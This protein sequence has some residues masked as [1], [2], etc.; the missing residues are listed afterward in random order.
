MNEAEWTER[1]E[2]L[3]RDHR[4]LKSFAL[5]VFFLALALAGIYAIRPARKK[6]TARELDI[7]DSAGTVR[8]RLAVMQGGP[9]MVLYN[10]LGKPRALM[11]LSGAGT[12][13]LGLYDAQGYPRASMDVT[14]DGA[15]TLRLSD[16]EGFWMDLGNAKTSTA[17][18]GKVPQS[19]ADSIVMFG[20]GRVI[21][22]AP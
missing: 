7:M 18:A 20:G 9:A 5:A 2:R 1:F 21:W 16:P 22:R 14:G 6:V 8:I 12:P 11:S 19:S 3:E 13:S 17:S 10:A 15:P 4:R